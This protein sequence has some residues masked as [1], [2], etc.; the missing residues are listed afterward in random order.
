MIGDGLNFILNT[1]IPII[2]NKFEPATYSV[3]MAKC[4]G[5]GMQGETDKTVG[6]VDW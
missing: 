5:L 3:D 4:H 1:L 6:L 2:G